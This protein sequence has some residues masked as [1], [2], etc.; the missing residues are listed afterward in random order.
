M[1]NIVYLPGR[2]HV[3]CHLLH[4]PLSSNTDAR[5]AA[6]DETGVQED[7]HVRVVASMLAAPPPAPQR[8]CILATSASLAGHII[9]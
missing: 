9:L 8:A 3:S 7:C 1:H 5:S 4:Y 6:W 2:V